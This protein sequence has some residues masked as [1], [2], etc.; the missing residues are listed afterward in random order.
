VDREL[1]VASRKGSTYW[2]R[3]G[4]AA[5]AALVAAAAWVASEV[6][7]GVKFGQTLFW[8]LAAV[9]MIHCL[10][11]GRRS[12][13]DCL[14]QE[15]R[16]GTMGLLFLTDLKGFDVVIGKLVANSLGGFYG[17]LAIFP[18]LAVPLLV[19]GMTS[20]ELWRMALALVVT[21]VFSL[22]IGVFCSAGS[23]EYK[24]AIGRNF[25][26]LTTLTVILPIIGLFV[27]LGTSASSTVFFLASPISV[28]RLCQDTAY[29][30]DATT[31]WQTLVTMLGLSVL[32]VMRACRLAPVS[33]QDQPPVRRAAPIE[34]WRRFKRAITYGGAEERARFRKQA[35]DINGYFWL[36]ARERLK[37]AHVWAFLAGAVAWWIIGWSANGMYWLNEISDATMALLLTTM[38]KLWVTVEAGQRL[39]TDREIGA[40]E[41]LLCTSLTVDDFLRGQFLA[42]RRQF[43]KP[44]LAVIGAMLVLMGIALQHHGEHGWLPWVAAMAMLVADVAALGPVGI[45][46][47]LRSKTHTR[48]TLATAWRILALPWLGL[49]V[50]L[51]TIQALRQLGYLNSAE[52][53]DSFQIETWFF[54]GICVD[55]YFGWRAWSVLRVDFRDLA[56]QRYGLRARREA[57]RRAA[58]RFR[59]R[60]AIAATGAALLVLSCVAWVD[61]RSHY[62][63]PVRVTLSASNGPAQVFPG[64]NTASGILLVLPDGTLWRWGQ[65]EGPGFARAESPEEVGTNH[66][67]LKVEVF[68]QRLFGLR[69]DGTIWEW[70]AM[71]NGGNIAEPTQRNKDS[72]WMDIAAVL[73]LRV[74]VKRDGTLWSWARL[75]NSPGGF[76]GRPAHQVGAET[77]WAKLF[78]DAIM[79]RIVAVQSNGTTW[80]WTRYQNPV[81]EAPVLTNL[82]PGALSENLLGRRAGLW[83]LIT[84]D[85]NGIIRTQGIDYSGGLG[86]SFLDRIKFVRS[87]MAGRGSPELDSGFSMSPRPLM[88]LLYP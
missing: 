85:P 58:S 3:L 35:L 10:L 49:G 32:F 13:A 82:D 1:R 68:R 67:W 6:R 60:P 78:S 71:P 66:D 21:F 77:N 44:L 34:W 12:T 4:V 61:S 59:A 46:M 23:R 72:N 86:M 27:E 2:I 9:A 30:G 42:L 5:Q 74:G 16:E 54:F 24:E 84:M 55:I 64:V 36:A 83:P 45:W 22:A 80:V 47:A 29:G 87:G 79:G 81:L 31:Y 26:L 62:P 14:S 41:L 19:G 37:P 57:K 48:A 40:M 17:L 50:V 43:L 76:R 63:A 11:A 51:L 38:L 52:T 28:F 70:R 25:L 20:G 65:P 7:P 53:S 73:E 39:A 69:G 33:W 56:M 15:K 88:K 18:V 75:T 8:G